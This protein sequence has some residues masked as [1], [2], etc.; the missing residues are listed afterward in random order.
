MKILLG[1]YVNQ[2]NAYLLK[3]SNFGWEGSLST[4]DQLS[5]IAG[6][7]GLVLG[8]VIMLMIT[9]NL[10][11]NIGCMYNFGKKAVGI[12]NLLRR[13]TNHKMFM[14]SMGQF[15]TFVTVYLIYCFT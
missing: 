12:E 14:F 9:L 6:N 11:S 8:F 15:K 7:I 4:G 2:E 10:V 5:I 3:W 13:K 1:G